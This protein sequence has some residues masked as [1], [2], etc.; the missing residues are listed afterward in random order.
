[1]TVR[2]WPASDSLWKWGHRSGGAI[3]GAGEPAFRLSQASANP[4]PVLI[5]VPHAGRGYSA[6]L[7]VRMRD[8]A[9]ATMRLEDRR[10]DAVGQ[11]IAHETGAALLVAHAPR[12]LIDLNRAPDD[13]DWD[14]VDQGPHRARRQ[15]A[16]RRSRSGLGLIPRR[17]SGLG[18]IWSSRL[19]LADVEQRIADVHRPYHQTLGLCLET[20]RDKWGAALLIDLHSMPPLAGRFAGEQAP[21]FVIGDRFGASCDSQLSARALAYLGRMGRPVS[22]NR[23]YAGGYV[24]DRHAQPARGIHCLQLEVC[25]SAY[26]DPALAEPSARLPS[27]ARLLSGLVRD[28]ATMM[29]GVVSGLG[30]GPQLPI[31]AE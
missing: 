3:P 25:R 9:W 13:L 28:L 23:P 12:A 6:D 26:L 18:E 20:L 11:A 16:S 27:V 14:M 10:I 24:L 8:A 1:M 31:A 2:T 22:H 29:S 19:P 21:E 4:V 17:L 30:E 5:S 7:L 15:P